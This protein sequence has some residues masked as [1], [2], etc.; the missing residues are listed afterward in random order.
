[1]NP[2]PPFATPRDLHEP[3][4]GRRSLRKGVP[5][6]CVGDAY[7]RSIQ[8]SKDP[9][10][11]ISC[12]RSPVRRRRSK[13]IKAG[14]DY[15]PAANQDKPPNCRTRTGAGARGNCLDSSLLIGGVPSLRSDGTEFLFAGIS[16]LAVYLTETCRHFDGSTNLQNLSEN[17]RLTTTKG[18]DLNPGKQ[19][20]LNRIA[21]ILGR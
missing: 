2:S 19:R 4:S 14:M 10:T 18:R 11:R 3:C 9:V 17:L 16:S 20:N 15:G 6:R 21:R 5:H 7:G 13:P 1:M 8:R 12:W